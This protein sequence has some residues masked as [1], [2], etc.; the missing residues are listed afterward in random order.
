M[1]DLQKVEGLD[2]NGNLVTVY[3]KNPSVKDYRESQIAYS[4]AFREALEG[5][6][7]LRESLKDHMKEQGV[8][9]DAKDK[10]YKKIFEELNTREN[11]LKAGGVPLKKAKE[12]AL[13]MRNLRAE[14]NELLTERQA[15]ESNCVEGQADNARFNQ[16]VVCCVVDENGRRIWSNQ[17]KYDEQGDE[18]WA[19]K[20]ASELANRLY[21]IDSQYYKT[22][23]ENEFLVKY[24]F[25]N[26]DLRLVNKDGH[27]VDADGRL[28][29]EDG[30]FVAYR[31]DGT[32][33]FVNRD[34]QEVDENGDLLI[35][36][37]PFLDDDGNPVVLDEN[38]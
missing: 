9:D 5:G 2:K 29:N 1:K 37:S 17:E 33:Y 7:M 18:P 30:R 21:G 34:G 8:W 11:V 19:H 36:F 15:A 28:I 3:L 20:A 27:L 22:L 23:P 14:L 13:E 26:K 38:D 35:E 12:I 10:Q 16:L 4:K 31:E 6:A 24:K 32:Q 25:A